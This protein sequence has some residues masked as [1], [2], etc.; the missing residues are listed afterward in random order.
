MYLLL[1]SRCFWRYNLA[2]LIIFCC[3]IMLSSHASV[4]RDPEGSALTSANTR[5]SAVEQ[6]MSISPPLV[7]KLVSTISYP[8]SIKKAAAL[9]SPSLPTL[10]VDRPL[11]ILCEDSFPC[12]SKRIARFYLSE[13]FERFNFFKF[14]NWLYIFFRCFCIRHR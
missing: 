1:Y 5:V 12:E 8:C 2:V 7:L 4:S 10:Q 13:F 14:L 11:F 3:F 6:M 9:R